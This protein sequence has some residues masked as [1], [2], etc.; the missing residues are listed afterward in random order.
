LP[1]QKVDLDIR[2]ATGVAVMPDL[3]YAFVADYDFP[4]YYYYP[5][6]PERAINDENLHQIGSKIGII[7]NPFGTPVLVGAT[8]P[9]PLGFCTSI[10]LSGDGTKL[11]AIYQGAA[12]VLVFDV[13]LLTQQVTNS[14]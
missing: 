14:K 10:V 2:N 3:S 5:D 8:S 7:Q 12:Q 11:Y 1:V 6:N 13:K 9:I 4:R